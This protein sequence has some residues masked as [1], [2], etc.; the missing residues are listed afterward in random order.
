[1]A[2]IIEGTNCPLIFCANVRTGSTAIANAMMD[3]GARRLGEHHDHPLYIPPDS[4]V[5][6]TVRCP[7]EVFTSLWFKGRPYECFEHFVYA[8][9]RGEYTHVTIPMYPRLAITHNV[10]YN[11][12]EREFRKLCNMAG[13]EPEPMKRTPSR[14]PCNS[15]HMFSRYLRQLVLKTFG[16]EMK[17]LEI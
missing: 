1:M 17:R 8:A 13:V 14:T 3:M 5:F 16:K 7:F 15:D 2:Y 9:C 4:I 6:Q 11:R 10:K 12:L